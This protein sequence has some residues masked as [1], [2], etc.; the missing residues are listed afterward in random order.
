MLS[1]VGYTKGGSIIDSSHGECYARIDDTS[2]KSENHRYF[3][4]T[5]RKVNGG[6]LEYTD[7]LSPNA[8]MKIKGTDIEGFPFVEVNKLAFDHYLNYLKSKN[9]AN[10]HL[11][12]RERGNT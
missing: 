11:A 6:F 1:Y 9:L 10:L 2:Q 12:N 7:M 3:I 4:R 8:N 5:N